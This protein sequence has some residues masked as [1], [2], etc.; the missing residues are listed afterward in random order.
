MSRMIG[1]G[2]WSRMKDGSGLGLGLVGALRPKGRLELA[3]ILLQR[4]LQLQLVI[5]F[6]QVDLKLA[7]LALQPLQI[8]LLLLQQPV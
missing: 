3:P 6:V 7:V 2:W 4:S 1:R 5:K 8:V